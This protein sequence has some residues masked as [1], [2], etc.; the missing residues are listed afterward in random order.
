MNIYKINKERLLA[1]I[2]ILIISSI[3]YALSKRSPHTILSRID[4]S[5]LGYLKEYAKISLIYRKLEKIYINDV[6]VLGKIADIIAEPF[7]TRLFHEYIM[8]YLSRGIDLSVL[9][10]LALRVLTELKQR[11]SNRISLLI[12]WIELLVLIISL[13]SM[14]T[15][16]AG[17][18]N[19]I[20]FSIILILITILSLIVIPFAKIE[21]LDIYMQN[22]NSNVITVS[23]IVSVVVIFLG[24]YLRNIYISTFG[25]IISVMTVIKSY[26]NIIKSLRKI[27]DI[28]YTLQLLAELLAISTA[29]PRIIEMLTKDPRVP[30]E[31]VSVLKG[32][33]LRRNT[34]ERDKL[35]FIVSQI[36]LSIIRGGREAIASIRL[37]HSIIESIYK[38]VKRVMMSG[39]AQLA[40]LTGS[41][42]ILL[43]VFK[44]LVLLFG[45]NAFPIGFSYTLPISGGSMSY[46]SLIVVLSSSI[47]SIAI[48]YAIFRRAFTANFATPLILYI[49]AILYTKIF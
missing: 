9:D 44:Y 8:V 18:S 31:I 33:S 39:I 14:V 23:Y 27:E 5:L 10:G 36:L 37:I 40:L 17:L 15:F 2:P 4:S 46:T 48:S 11:I 12:Q 42:L 22:N 1:E 28:L 34:I 32:V 26:I 20:S 3:P 47:S 35:V 19:S 30:R 45:A 13:F 29:S 16:L 38:A 7:L 6:T 41:V 21:Y 43:F 24:L 25:F 49:S